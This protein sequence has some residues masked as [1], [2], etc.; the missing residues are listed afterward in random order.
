VKT[1][2]GWTKER[3]ALRRLVHSLRVMVHDDDL[4]TLGEVD[5]EI[6][7]LGI[8]VKFSKMRGAPKVP[9]F[10]RKPCGCWRQLTGDGPE[11]ARGW[12]K[13][14]APD[15]DRAPSAPAFTSAD[16]IDPVPVAQHTARTQGGT[17]IAFP[18][19]RVKR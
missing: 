12:C 2:G 19:A 18:F 13:A 14:H 16:S 7:R 9:E 11:R 8:R 17:V 3:A 10:E 5:D 4:T 1:G 15:I 6:A